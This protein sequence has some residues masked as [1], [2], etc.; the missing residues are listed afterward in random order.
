MELRQ[1]TGQSALRRIIEAASEPQD[2]SSVLPVIAASLAECLGADACHVWLDVD[3]PQLAAA[4]SAGGPGVTRALDSRRVKAMLASDRLVVEGVWTCAPLPSCGI[5]T[6]SGRVCVARSLPLRPEEIDLLRGAAAI[7][8]LVLQSSADGGLDDEARD[9]FLALLGHDLRSPLANVRIGAQL[10][11]RNLD[12]GDLASVAQALAIIE[13]QSGR[14]MDRLEALLDALAATGRLLIRL[15]PLDLGKQARE[16]AAGYELAAR[17][18]GTG[19]RFEVRL[20]PAT[21]PVRG[22]ASQ[23]A[24]VVEHLID[25]AAKYAAGGNVT[26]SVRPEGGA[27]RLD[28]TDDGPGI[29]PEDVDRIFAPFGRGRDAGGKHGYGLGLYLARNIVR[30]HGG[31]LF[32]ER[33]SRSG[34]TMSVLLPAAD[35]GSDP[36]A[37]G[38]ADSMA[39]A[40]AKIDAGTEV[41]R[42]GPG[43]AEKGNAQ[44]PG[45]GA[46]PGD[47]AGMQ[48]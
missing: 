14:L 4:H 46:V 21:P 6:E 37:D 32:I 30:S 25:N 11:R 8:R 29:R 3:G 43:R 33:T 2:R 41:G 28:V 22:D 12:A 7:V 10:A 23:V 5:G 44:E 45:G 35:A 1:A 16:I 40:P 39:D 19:T 27:V 15:E 34:T 9:E 20:A 31:K 42:A 38:A 18:D 48:W 17:E 36:T 47:G 13:G 26:V 24:R